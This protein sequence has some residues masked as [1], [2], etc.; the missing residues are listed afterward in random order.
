MSAFHDA[1]EVEAQSWEILRPLIETRAYNGRYVRTAKGPL[2]RE[3]QRQVGDVLFNSDDETVW[4]CEIKAERK[5]TGNVFL[6]RWSNRSRFTPGW[7]ETL[8]C[9]L[10]LYHFLDADVLYGFHFDKLRKWFYH[11]EHRA[12]PVASRYPQAAQ[13][14]FNQMNDTWG[15]LVPIADVPRATMVGVWYPQRMAATGDLFGDAA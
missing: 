10:L 3:L 15:Y 14:R 4:T 1:C 6:E 13:S 9:D 5:H 7:F 2:A 11:C 12:V 8:Q